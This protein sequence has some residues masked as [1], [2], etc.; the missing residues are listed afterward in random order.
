M[1]THCL[2]RM[3]EEDI[4]WRPKDRSNSVGNPVLHLCGNEAASLT[5][6]WAETN[7]L[8]SYLNCKLSPHWL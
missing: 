5:F 1:L 8:S 7:W 4:W 3:T 2:E 6:I